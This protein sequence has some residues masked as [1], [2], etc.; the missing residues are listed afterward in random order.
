M[1][2]YPLWK[3]VLVGLALLFGLVYTLPNFFGESPA[4]QVSSAKATLK[5]DAS[6]RERVA[7]TLQ[8]AGIANSG[9][10]LD[11]NGVKV[12]LLTNDTQLQAKD[13]LEKKFNPDSSDPQY[14]IAL[15]LLSSSPQW[16]TK[17]HAL[18]M[19][20]GLDLRGGVHFLLQVDMPGALTKR[21]DSIGADLRTLLRD[22]N[23]RHAGIDREGERVVIRFRDQEKLSKGR[24]TLE[25]NQPDL[26]LVEQG[27]GSDL[28]LV[29]T[30]RP[31]AIKRI[32]DFALKQNITTLNNRINELGVAEPVIAQQG[33]DRIVV[34]L[35]GVQDT[36]KAKDILGRTATLEIRMVEENP[37]AVEAA[38]AGQVPFGS[39]LYVERGGA[40]LL[41]KKQVVLTGDRL[42]DAQPGFDSQTREPAVHL[43]LD[44]PGARI[45]K[46]ITRDN[47]GKRMAILLIE[48]NKGEVVT[49]PVIRAEIGGGRVQI[50]GRMTTTEANDTALLLRAGSLAAPMEIIEERTIG[51]SLGAENIK[52]G[53]QSTMWGFVAI[54]VFM[55]AYYLLFGVVSV[56][57]LASNLLF[58]VALLSMLQATLTLPGIAAIALT[59][60]MAI[61]ANVLINERI[62]E[63]LRNGSS[64][65]AAIHTGYERAFGT[66]L[67]SNITTLIAGLALL[68]FG[69]GPV[70]GFAVVHCLGIMTSLFSAVVVS[71]A[72]INL[73]YGRRRKL[74]ALAIGQ[75]WKPANAG[76]AAVN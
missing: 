68:M 40:P 58:L 31:E 63:E 75:V 29:A 53:F 65:Q 50:S 3:Y 17:L 67:D 39:E 62:R 76:S 66:I 71:R 61:D 10:F 47:V 64:P 11:S 9:I 38:L 55:I 49:A 26:L 19:Y 41:V 22:N 21:L 51:P 56:I 27:E 74:E 23:V 28:K 1:N 18:P 57:A 5:I 44:S 12:R 8:A 20:L 13:I 34:Q 32:Q 14:V 60:G 7:S 48:K 73:I 43:T 25:E 69:S 33:A 30:L 36:A 15:N 46:D 2:R 52:K 72:L 70:R 35:P 42:T 16:L 54:A 4:V 24:L 59:L 6:T 45:F 37:G